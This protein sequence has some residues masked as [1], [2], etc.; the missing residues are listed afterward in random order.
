[1]HQSSG[2]VSRSWTEGLIAFDDPETREAGVVTSVLVVEDNP[3][4]ANLIRSYLAK[5]FPDVSPCRVERMQLALDRLGAERFDLVLLDLNLPDTNG[6][7][8]LRVLLTAAP[9]VPVV[10]LT[11]MNDEIMAAECLRMGAQDYIPKADMTPAFL[12]RVVAHALSRKRAEQMRHK[13]AHINRLASLGKIAASVAHE[14]NNPATVVMAHLGMARDRVH[15]LQVAA[16][17]DPQWGALKGLSADLTDLSQML[18][19]GIEG[20]NAMVDAVSDLRTFS[21]VEDEP[22]LVD[23]ETTIKKAIRLMPPEGRLKCQIEVTLDPLPQVLARAQR[24]LQV[25]LNLLTNALHAVD[26]NV[27][28]PRLI[29]VLAHVVD[30]EI[31]VRIR[32][33]GC[34]M[35]DAVR[36]RVFEPFFTTRPSEVGTG[37]GLA[38]VADFISQMGGGILCHSDEGVG[39]EFEL[40]LPTKPVDARNEKQKLSSVLPGKHGPRLRVLFVDDDPQVLR[41]VGRLLQIRY[42]V[43]EAASAHAALAHLAQDQRFDLVI[44]DHHMPVMSG[45]ELYDTLT[46]K[47]PAL[48]EHFILVSGAEPSI[49]EQRSQI[50]EFIGKPFTLEDVARVARKLYEKVNITD[51]VQ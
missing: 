6:L 28:R 4:D 15:E 44:A 3:G 35:P 5:V 20:V 31:V 27:N 30:R 1:M 17:L 25:F 37:L 26:A 14:V 42:E 48:A 7:D 8:T 45:R 41:S 47:F 9:E 49:A 40:R 12:K 51:L 34:G 29:H 39:T 2:E 36:R 13:V 18:D 33:N 46:T 21:R 16:S 24:L 19:S 11:G 10:V 22:T 38:L 50:P 43:V 32:D 23:V